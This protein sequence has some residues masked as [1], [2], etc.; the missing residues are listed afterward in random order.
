MSRK[1]YF[2][3]TKATVTVTSQQIT[4][5]AL[6]KCVLINNGGKDIIFEFDNAIEATSPVLPAGGSLDL[7]AG[8][9][10]LNVKTAT[11]ETTL[12]IAGR[13]QQKTPAA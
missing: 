11:G 8:F 6:N 13:R 2:Y 7:G 12:Y 5:P 10:E 1:T 4:L 3:K 9:V